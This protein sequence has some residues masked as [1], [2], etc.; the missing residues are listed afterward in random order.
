MANDTRAE[1][2]AGTI[3]TSFNYNVNTTTW[4]LVPN[5]PLEHESDDRADKAVSSVCV[6]NGKDMALQRQI[7]SRFATVLWFHKTEIPDRAGRSTSCENVV[8][9]YFQN[10]LT[11]L[12]Q[13]LQK[14]T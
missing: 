8:S 2:Y 10:L 6:T 13:F 4:K 3:M 11:I 12:A 7:L 5:K 1:Y 14:Y 9:Y